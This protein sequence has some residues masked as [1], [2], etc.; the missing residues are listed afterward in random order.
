LSDS[1]WPSVFAVT[2][3]R[4][5]NLGGDPEYVDCNLERQCNRSTRAYAGVMGTLGFAWARAS[6]RIERTSRMQ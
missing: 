5:A 1:T 2:L 4:V 3:M 6:G